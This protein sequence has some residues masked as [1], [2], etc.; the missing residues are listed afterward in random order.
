MFSG[1]SLAVQVVVSALI[2]GVSVPAHSHG[3]DAPGPHNGSIRMPGAFHTEV[4]QEAKDTYRVYL[5]DFQFKNPSVKDS[6]V[7]AR[8]ES[9]GK[10]TSLGCAKGANAFVCTVPKSE[11]ARGQQKGVLVIQAT[12]ENAKG[13]EVRYDLP[14][15]F[16]G[17]SDSKASKPNR[18]STHDGHGS[19]HH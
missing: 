16:A 6:T 1:S 14:L 3:E 17:A 4:V 5:L 8:I 18:P 2:L 10:T 12:R 7:R 11:A 19:H 9:S 13:N 15:R